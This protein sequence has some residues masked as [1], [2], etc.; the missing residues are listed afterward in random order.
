MA[1][2]PATDTVYVANI[3]DASVSV[4]DS[5]TCNGSDIAGYSRAPPKLA[6]GDYPSALAVDPA[7]GTAYVASGTESTVSVNPLTGVLAAARERGGPK[8]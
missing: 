1:I 6:V 4:I 7:V 8:R 2:D 3:E 5:A